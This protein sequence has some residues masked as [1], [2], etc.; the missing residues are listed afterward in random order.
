[1]DHY[2]KTINVVLALLFV[3]FL[4]VDDISPAEG[5]EIGQAVAFPK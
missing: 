4:L 3:G 1:M 2:K 5:V